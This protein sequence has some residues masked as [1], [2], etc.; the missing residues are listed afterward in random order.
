MGNP[1]GALRTCTGFGR[2]GPRAAIGLFGALAALAA[3]LS[4]AADAPAA[5]V[6]PAKLVVVSDVN[7]PPYLFRA[8]DGQL[9][10]I[11]Q[12]K[13]ALWSRRTGVPA[14]VM[15][16]EWSKAQ[17][18]VLDGAADVIEALAYTAARTQLYEY[19]PPYAPIEARVYF[20]QTI[21]GINDVASL[22]GFAIGAKQGSACGTWLADHGIDTIYG[23]PTSETLVLAA[24]AGDVRLFC[25]DSAVAQ[26]FLYKLGLA[27]QFRQTPP[28]YTTQFHWAVKKG[29]TELRDFI[30]RGFEQITPDELRDIDTLWLGNPLR[31]PIG[32]RYL[33]YLGFFAAAIVT[34]AALLIGW[35]RSLRARVAAK[36]AELS[37]ALGAVRNYADDVADLY[38]NAPCGYHCLDQDGVVVQINDTELKWLGRT[39]DEVVGQLRF[40]DLLTDE[41]RRNFHGH[42]ARFKALGTVSD[43]EYE[44]VR[45]DG[46]IL[47]VMISASTVRDRDGNYL[48]SRATVYDMTDRKQVEREVLRLNAELERR[49]EERTRQLEVANR[50]LESFSYSVSHDLRSPLRG[51]DGFSQLL[52]DRN[53]GSLDAES[54]HYLQRVR[55]AAQRMGMLIDDLLSLS[56]ITRSK[57][58]RRRVDLSA[59]AKEI[60]DEL[61]RAEPER[62]VDCRI[63]PGLAAD[64]DPGLMRAMLQ[65]LLGN[66]WKFTGKR[67]R[68]RV[69][70]GRQ[71]VNGEAVFFI[72]DNG[73]G[74]NM[75]YAA[76][77]FGAFQR[78][79]TSNEF[80]GT[81]IGLATVQRIVSRHG[82]RIWAEG[83]PDEG[84]TF[85]FQ[86]PE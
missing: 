21:S 71:R 31:F 10:G 8:A 23:Y 19:S 64:A 61:A 51:I 68:A 4:S 46:T 49:V 77:L 2:G 86:L 78:L 53:R 27:D 14:E 76:T 47:P 30:E 38:H 72:R 50:E 73:A 36:T 11:L 24:G 5:S 70:F 82:G 83:V 58:V 18:A 15:G 66:A 6:P 29:R 39:R 55:A 3:G 44:L 45:R 22:R 48:M 40:T 74:F 20:H 54:A 41:A 37:A 84:A 34:G 69:E 32:T 7:Y 59:L 81:G 67:A 56:Q 26:Y 35:N 57:L 1:T 42:F 17:A 43:V 80:E 63:A 28:L 33:Y 16:M 13:W 79:H 52:L 62:E 9:Q 60:L 12:D 65:N 25:M 75:D 85:F